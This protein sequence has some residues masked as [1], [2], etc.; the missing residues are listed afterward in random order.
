MIEKITK[1]ALKKPLTKV[2]DSSLE[3]VLSDGAETTIEANLKHN[4]IAIKPVDCKQVIDKQ[5]KAR[6][7]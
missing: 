7:L 3:G 1:Q 2:L 4:K 5:T 6:T